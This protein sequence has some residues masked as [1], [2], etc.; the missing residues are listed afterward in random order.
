MRFAF[1]PA[2]LLLA[3]CNEPSFNGA[4]PKCGSEFAR[5]LLIKSINE[6]PA[7]LAG[8]KA[9]RVGQASAWKNM[10]NKDEPDYTPGISQ[11]MFCDGEVFTNAGVKNVQFNMRWVD[12]AKKDEVWLEV[13]YGL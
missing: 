5:N 2:V 4:I 9:T 11:M 7:G 12:E 13:A 3:G 1:L 8:L 6:S 10:A